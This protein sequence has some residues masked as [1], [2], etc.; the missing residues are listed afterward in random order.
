MHFVQPFYHLYFV[1]THLLHLCKNCVYSLV[2][3]CFLNSNKQFVAVNNEHGTGRAEQKKGVARKVRIIWKY[4]RS[5]FRSAC[6]PSRADVGHAHS[7]LA[8]CML[9]TGACASC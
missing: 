6:S 1:H 4:C 2:N 5:A 8:S 7:D 3:E 9:L